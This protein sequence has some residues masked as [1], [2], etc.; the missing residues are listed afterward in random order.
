[1]TELLKTEAGLRMV[2]DYLD[3]LVGKFYKILPMWE[4]GD[5]TLAVYIEGLWMELV[6][7]REFVEAYGRYVVSMLSILQFLSKHPE[8][9]VSKV[10]REVFS[11]IDICKRLHRL[12]ERGVVT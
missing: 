4:N 3:G 1:M 6:G 10:R 11:A 9:E 2:Q 8:T 5:N 7:F 12:I